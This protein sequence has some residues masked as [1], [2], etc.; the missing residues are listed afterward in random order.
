MVP[1]HPGAPAP[2]SMLPLL[3]SS[4]SSSKLPLLSTS[5]SRAPA[6]PPAASQSDKDTTTVKPRLTQESDQSLL[7]FDHLLKDAG[8]Q[9]D[10]SFDLLNDQ[11]APSFLVDTTFLASPSS[12]E[13]LRDRSNRINSTTGTEE[14]KNCDEAMEKEA[15]HE[16]SET[17]LPTPATSQV[18]NPARGQPRPSLASRTLPSHQPNIVVAPPSLIEFTSEPEPSLRISEPVISAAPLSKPVERPAHI[19]PKNHPSHPRMSIASTAHPPKAPITD[20]SLPSTSSIES[21]ERSS[22]STHLDRRKSILKT[23]VVGVK[24]IDVQ[25]SEA[26]VQEKPSKVTRPSQEA[27]AAPVQPNTLQNPP[28]LSPPPFSPILP[29]RLR[30]EN[31]PEQ[32]GGEED[33]DSFN[34]PGG[35]YDWDAA[36]PSPPRAL[37]SVF[38]HASTSTPHPPAASSVKSTLAQS[39]PRRETLAVKFDLPDITETSN[40]ITPQDKLRAQ[41]NLVNEPISE[42]VA[43]VE[44]KPPAKRRASRAFVEGPATLQVEEIV[45]KQRLS[46]SDG[47]PPRRASRVLSGSHGSSVAPPAQPVSHPAVVSISTQPQRA[48][49]LSI[50]PS[51]DA[52]ASSIAQSVTLQARTNSDRRA[53]T[54]TTSLTAP[55]PGT[56]TPAPSLAFSKKPVEPSSSM[57]ELAMAPAAAGPAEPKISLTLPRDFDFAARAA[58]RE[59]QRRK[60]RAEREKERERAAKEKEKLSHSGRQAKRPKLASSLPATHRSTAPTAPIPF[61]AAEPVKKPTLSNPPQLP[62]DGVPVTSG[63]TQNRTSTVPG[64]VQVPVPLTKEALDESLKLVGPKP[65]LKRRVSQYLEGVKEMDDQVAEEALDEEESYAD[66]P[67]ALLPPPPSPPRQELFSILTHTAEPIVAPPTPAKETRPSKPSMTAPSKRATTSQVT[68]PLREPLVARDNHSKAS[69]QATVPKALSKS[70]PRPFNFS[71][72]VRRDPSVP[73]REPSTSAMFDERLSSWRSREAAPSGSGP[74]TAMFCKVA[75]QPQ[76][77]SKRFKLDSGNVAGK[78]EEK[79]SWDVRQKKRE[80]AV[81]KAKEDKRKQEEEEERQRLKELRASLIAKSRPPTIRG[82]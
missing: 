20:S 30:I 13:S 9:G 70:K 15:E 23:S 29:A 62:T 5:Q 34:I 2:R 67:S 48:P 42:A 59:E 44:A 43:A 31:I 57:K 51:S 56:S 69:T 24:M 54:F 73:L 82:R 4:T 26:A 74:A 76:T 53:S 64:A 6:P 16:E 77:Q 78:V 66:P 45:K 8:L 11:V 1:L 68:N 65:D 14:V 35:M 47:T 19:L 72:R 27:T 10:D 55:I 3:K 38:V 39:K 71:T 28:S 58:E 21:R 61:N 41:N 79:D 80:E 18:M 50:A 37:H 75:T 46:V 49:R 33:D 12:S 63:I 36:I 22:M 60:K 52:T 32:P 7:N 25:P 17:T 40:E 81:R